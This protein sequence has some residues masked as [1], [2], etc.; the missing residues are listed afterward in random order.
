MFDKFIAGKI[1]L[2]EYVHRIENNGAAFYVNYWGAILKHY[3]NLPHKHSFFEVCY[4]LDGNGVYVEGDYAYPIQKNTM[5]FSRPDIIH[6]IQSE[7]GLSLLYVGFDLIESD[8]SEE[9]IHK[10]KEA[11]QCSEFIIDKHKE[12]A[13][14]MIWKSLLLQAAKAEHIFFKGI[15]DNLASSLIFSIVEAFVPKTEYHNDKAISKKSS[16]MLTQAKLFIKDNLAASLK[17]TETAGHLH[18]SSRHL[19]RLFASKLG[20]SYTEYVQNERIQQAAIL[21]KTT[22]LL[23]KDIAEE[24]GFSNIH[25]FTRVFHSAMDCSPG[26]FRKLYTKLKTITYKD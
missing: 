7:K 16:I 15:L 14:P 18:I 12:E 8:S 23:I 4:V 6:Q 10:M 5:L 2:N 13:I 26:R 11:T 17:L 25:H 21:L 19:S 24:T 22:D 3:D 20:I 1:A 9:W